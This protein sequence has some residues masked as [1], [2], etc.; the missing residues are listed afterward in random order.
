MVVAWDLFGNAQA[1]V[2]GGVEILD[3]IQDYSSKVAMINLHGKPLALQSLTWVRTVYFYSF[4]RLSTRLVATLC[5][6]FKPTLYMHHSLCSAYPEEI[7]LW[8]TQPH[9][10]PS[11][12]WLAYDTHTHTHT[13]THTLA[14]SSCL[15]MYMHTLCHTH[16]QSYTLKLNLDVGTGH[17]QTLTFWRHPLLRCA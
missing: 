16:V 5:L 14:L 11:M 17:V 15:Y 7:G 10:Q 3:I 12:K 13:H 2:A 4:S 8:L 6:P 9:I 1:R